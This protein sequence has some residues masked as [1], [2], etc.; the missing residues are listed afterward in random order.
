MS[1]RFIAFYLPQFYPF[2]ENNSWWGKG[3]TEWTNVTKAKPLF[4][5]H[6]QPFLPADLGFYDLRLRETQHEQI[7]LAKKYGIDAFC[8]HYYWFNGKRLLDIPV[9]AFLTD[10]SANI[11]FCLC[12]ANENWTRRWDA[13]EH[14]ILIRQDY[15]PGYEIAFI[16]GVIPFFR[17]DRY[18]RVDGRPVLVVYRP[19]HMPNPRQTAQRWREHCRRNGIGE[20][21]LVAALIRGNSTFDQFGFDAGVEFPP[22]NLTTPT[23]NDRVPTFEAFNGAF[24]DYP[25]VARSYLDRD[26]RD[27]VVYRTVF[28]SW[29][30][31]ARVADR[32]LVVLGASPENYERWLSGATALTSAERAPGQQLVF[33]NA[34]NEWAEGCCLEPSRAFGLGFL[35]AT[36]RVKHGVSTT[37]QVYRHHPLLCSEMESAGAP[38]GSAGHSRLGRIK[39]WAHHALRNNPRTFQLARATYSLARRIRRPLRTKMTKIASKPSLINAAALAES[40]A[41]VFDRTAFLDARQDAV[42]TAF[43]SS[44]VSSKERAE[45]W[46]A[47]G[48]SKTLRLRELLSD[49]DYDAPP[50][51]F[52]RYHNCTAHP[53]AVCLITQ[54]GALIVESLQVYQNV[55]V[56]LSNLDHLT[57]RNGTYF[58]LQGNAELINEDV[59][60]PFHASFAFGHCMFDVLPQILLFEEE[61]RGG[62]LKIVLPTEH[63]QWVWNLLSYWGFTSD[64]VVQLPSRAFRFR[65]AIVSNAL[66]TLSS[67]YPNPVS[68]S[69]YRQHRYAP[70]VGNWQSTSGY[71]VYLKRGRAIAF[72]DRS[73]DNEAEVIRALEGLG[74]RIIEPDRL[75]Y[76]DQIHIFQNASTIIGAHGWAFANLI[77]CRPGTRVIDLMPD[78]WIGY[79]GDD[80]IVELWVARICAACDLKYEVFLNASRCAQR[81]IAGQPAPAISSHVDVDDLLRHLQSIPAVANQ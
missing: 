73:I 37:D 63:P 2:P 55:D 69:Q 24:F 66:T 5:G 19:Q 41:K 47:D 64:Q 80:G 35:E 42:W 62:S 25:S 48:T 30:N 9:D 50:L 33:I 1:V 61:I 36:W 74:F 17:D 32:A 46:A 3:F 21:H 20:I 45:F 23:V 7:A 44:A 49:V 29:D 70:L 57:F 12:W 78:D 15:G 4:E 11:S 79:W 72:S 16:E 10:R 14:E 56:R 52:G 39:L 58:R 18:L 60:L 54:N 77:W 34:W 67:F 43:A 75:S 31:T 68:I 65:S 71:S 8:F 51:Q 26:Y 28:P 6:H 81:W 38:V 53:R 13:A 40:G 22:H 27:T 76:A 59:I